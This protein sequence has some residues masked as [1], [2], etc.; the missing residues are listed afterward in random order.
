M[1]RG[2]DLLDIACFDL[3][4]IRKD[5]DLITSKMEMSSIH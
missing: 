2:F 3:V 5:N 1:D 4:K